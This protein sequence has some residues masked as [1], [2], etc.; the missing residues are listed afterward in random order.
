[1]HQQEAAGKSHPAF[2]DP[3]LQHIEQ[4]EI[5]QVD[6]N[7]ADQ[8]ARAAG[9]HRARGQRQRHQGQQGRRQRH[10][11]PPRQFAQPVGNGRVEQILG[12]YV[13]VGLREPVDRPG[14]VIRHIAQTDGCIEPHVQR[15]EGSDG[16]VGLTRR[17]R[18][19]V[20]VAQHQKGLTI[21]AL[22]LRRA[23]RDQHRLARGVIADEDVV[24][25]PPGLRALVDEKHPLA[26]GRFAELPRRHARN[27]GALLEANA[28]RRGL[29]VGPGPGKQGERGD[30][31]Q[32]GPR[33][34]Q[35]ADHQPQPPHPG[36]APDGHLGIEPHAGE[37]EQ[38]RQK[39]RQGDDD[40]QIAQRGQA[41]EQK[42]ILRA[43]L[44]IGRLTQ[45]ANEHQGDDHG[46]QHG[47]C[48]AEIAAHFTAQG[49]IEEHEENWRQ[50]R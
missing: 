28:Q 5:N 35:H 9:S 13:A 16:V 2:A 10:T 17:M 20:A 33:K 19:A 22:H 18:V 45:N 40:L 26:R 39:Q 32:N 14:F 23:R 36:G 15:I 37:G 47:E 3:A 4:V 12:G 27:V 25:H 24:R 11:Q 46:E 31:Q 34:A 42:H 49:Q 29:L 30:Q 50:G 6:Q 48:A 1:M 8:A 43:G 44:T 41:D 21:D 7:G 38:H